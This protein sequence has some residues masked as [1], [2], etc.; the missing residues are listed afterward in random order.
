MKVR[1]ILKKGIADSDGKCAGYEYVTV[2]VDVPA[3][4][5]SNLEVIGGEWI[6][7]ET[8]SESK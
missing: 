1:L 7:D 5:D 6:L 3:V 4:S 2:V 8:I